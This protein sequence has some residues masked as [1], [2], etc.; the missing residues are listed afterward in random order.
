MCQTDKHTSVQ[1][2]ESPLT[3][4]YLAAR[5]EGYVMF[6]ASLTW[7]NLQLKRFWKRSLFRLVKNSRNQDLQT[8]LF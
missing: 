7:N 1:A 8:T 6:N 3:K 5:S 2:A 4:E